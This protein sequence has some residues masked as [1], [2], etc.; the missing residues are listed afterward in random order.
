MNPG[1]P[2]GL[3]RSV[4]SLAPLHPRFA[5]AGDGLCLG[6]GEGDGGVGGVGGGGGGTGGRGGGDSDRDGGLGGGG[7]PSLRNRGSYFFR[8]I[9]VL[10]RRRG[11]LDRRRVFW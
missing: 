4:K 9:G 1:M 5:G 8:G 10:D 2:G 7:K 11:V 3:S 6:D